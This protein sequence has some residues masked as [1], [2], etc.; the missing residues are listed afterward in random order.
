LGKR[1]FEVKR[2]AAALFSKGDL[3]KI[4]SKLFESCL[5]LKTTA[6]NAQH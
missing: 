3:R 1:S 4:N 2:I 5:I 6:A